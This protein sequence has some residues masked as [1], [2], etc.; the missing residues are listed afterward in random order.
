MQ[1]PNPVDA[2]QELTGITRSTIVEVLRKSGRLREFAVDPDTFIEYAAKAIGDA[3]TR[4]MVEGVRYRKVGGRLAEMEQFASR[5][6]QAYV[7]RLIPVDKSI[8]KEIEIESDVEQ[9]FAKAL[10]A[11]KDITLFLKLPDW[12]LIPTPAGRYNPDWALIKKKRV[13]LYL[14]RE[15]KSAWQT[16]SLR[17]SEKAKIDCADKHYTAIGVDFSVATDAAQI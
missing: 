13:E 11:R 7:N 4:C 17:G 2:I 6:S 12:L 3:T 9:R 14:V 5:A 8:Y 10:D 15:T 16:L 1:L